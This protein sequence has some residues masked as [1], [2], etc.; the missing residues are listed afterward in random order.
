M[1]H[2]VQTINKL[3]NSKHDEMEYIKNGTSRRPK[4]KPVKLKVIPTAYAKFQV[5]KKSLFL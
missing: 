5:F 1:A 2:F 3:S 4:H